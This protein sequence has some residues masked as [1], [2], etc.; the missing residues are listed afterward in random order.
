MCPK[1]EGLG[2][3]TTVDLNAL[4]DRSKSLDGGA[5]LHPRFKPGMWYWK[6]YA[7]SA[8]FEN[9]KPLADY[10]EAEWD[11]LLYG[12][13]A[14]VALPSKGGPVHSDYEGLVGRFERLYIK[15]GP[16][17]MSGRDREIYFRFVTVGTCPLWRGARLNETALASRIGGTNIAEAAA[18]EATALLALLRSWKDAYVGGAVADPLLAILTERVGNLVAIGLGYLSLSRPTTTL[19]GGEGQ[20]IKTVRHLSSSLVDMLYVFDEPTVGLH[21]RDVDHLIGRLRKLRDHGNTVLVVEHD[22]DVIEAADW[23][24]DLGPGAGVAGGELVFE[25]AVESLRQ[26]NTPT[27]RYLER[28]LAPKTTFREPTG[29]LTVEHATRH[30]LKDVTVMIPTGVLTVVSGVAGSGKSTLVHDVFLARHPGAVVIDQ[31]AVSASIRSTPATYTGVMDAIRQLFARENNVSASL[32]SF[33]SEGA[34]P[35]CN[36]LGVTYVDLAFMDG[37]ASTCEVCEGRRFTDEVLAHT[38]Q[39]QSIADVLEMP[40]VEAVDFFQFEDGIGDALRALVDVG[41]GYLTLGQPTSTLSGGERQ[42]VKLATE[43]HKQGSVYVM[44]EPTTGLHMADVATILGL[45]DRLVEA[46]NTVVVIEHNLDVIRNADWVI[47]LGP[48]GEAA[49][50]RVLFE[51][52]PEALSQFNGSYTAEYLRR[53]R[54]RFERTTSPK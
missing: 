22:R 40:A 29:W 41:L 6:Y 2:E 45:L 54:N 3:T 34:C 7:L 37:V 9:A 53:D 49:G 36:G 35:N 31:S 42:R 44:D 4:L 48:E 28:T 32:F 25:G 13:E 39:G 43:L 19:S 8:L 18:M 11:A 38:V 50:G 51:G 33:N 5:I 1:C 17:A 14:T 26:T 12:A 46:G 47:D 30:N 16:G 20:R 21:A 27:G 52:T 15:K 10:T 23:V 24:I